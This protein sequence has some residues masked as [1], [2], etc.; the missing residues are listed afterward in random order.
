M[1]TKTDYP[2]DTG[3][4]AIFGRLLQN[5]KGEMSPDLARYVLT[6]GFDEVDQTRMLELSTRNQE[7]TLTAKEHDELMNYVR[8]S[9]LLAFLHGH[10]QKV[11][12]RK[13]G[14]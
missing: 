1:A 14:A 13:K 4:A 3:E 11:L 10:A 12:R 9:H 5:S 6:L 2:G 8:A 7:G